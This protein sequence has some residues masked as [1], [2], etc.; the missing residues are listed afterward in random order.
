MS[1][2][3]IPVVL[4]ADSG[5]VVPTYIS[6]YSMLKNA[7]ADREI[8]IYLLSP[9]DYSS[10]IA[11]WFKGLERIF[12]N[13]KVSIIDMGDKYRDIAIKLHHVRYPTFY[14]L[15]IPELLPQYD[16]CIYLDS[17]IVVEGDIAEYYDIDMEGYCIAGVKDIGLSEK[18]QNERMKIL[19]IDSMDEYINTGTLLMNLKQIRQMGLEDALKQGARRNYPCS[20]QDVLNAVCYGS[21][22]TLP[23]KYNAMTR[24]TYYGNREQRAMYG[25]GYAEAMTAPVVVHYIGGKVKPWV[26]RFVLGGSLWW[27]YV[28][29]LDEDDRKRFV[30]PFIAGCK[31]SMRLRAAVLCSSVLKK[32][33]LYDGIVKLLKS[34]GLFRKI[35][36]KL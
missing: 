27:K 1:D 14:R 3:V 23:L 5:F 22:K 28:R 32:L 11:G 17:D 31:P 34:T 12:A 21:I 36:K 16:K 35:K 7:S 15:S 30:E 18:E 6:L 4:A 29:E 26:S 8:D 24:C 13:A 19:N 2:R 10:D 9:G 25:E 33:G 20:D